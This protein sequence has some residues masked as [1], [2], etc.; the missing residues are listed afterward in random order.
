MTLGGF[1]LA[2]TQVATVIFLFGALATMVGVV[3]VMRVIGRAE[4]E[5]EKAI[6]LVEFTQSHSCSL[7]GDS[8]RV[9]PSF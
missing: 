1:P 2:D 7:N 3:N 6:T 9:L 4:E 8:D 5:E